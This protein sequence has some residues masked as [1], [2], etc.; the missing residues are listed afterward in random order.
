M[1]KTLTKNDAPATDWADQLQELRNRF[2][3]IRDT[4]LFAV[5][6]LQSDPDIAIDDL[7]ARADLHNI[8]VTKASMNAAERLLANAAPV[9]GKVA[10]PARK[11]PAA[12]ARNTRQRRGPAGPVD[13]EAV[14][15]AAVGQIEG[16]GNV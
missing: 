5:H 4:I 11:A 1:T 12:K 15:R 14:I 6:T 7:K 8:R 3:K 2:P 16:Q 9:N 13:V 10:K